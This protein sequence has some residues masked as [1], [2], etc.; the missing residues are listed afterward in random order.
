M[1]NLRLTGC[2]TG[3]GRLLRAEAVAQDAPDIAKRC[4]FVVSRALAA[5]PKLLDWCAPLCA[6]DGLV[7]MLKGQAWADTERKDTIAAAKTW[8]MESE[9]EVRLEDDDPKRYLVTW[10]KR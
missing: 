1:P 4:P 6:K 3:Q 8:R 7:L 9:V 10:S 5:G 2:E